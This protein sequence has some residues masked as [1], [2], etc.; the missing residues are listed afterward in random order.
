[1]Q[2]CMTTIPVDNSFFIQRSL[3]F[4]GFRFNKLTFKSINIMQTSNN[5]NI[6]C[7]YN[8]IKVEYSK[9]NRFVIF[10]LNDLSF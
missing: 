9:P 2:R 1:M 3:Q 5:Y 7:R 6:A 8:F 4:I 10:I